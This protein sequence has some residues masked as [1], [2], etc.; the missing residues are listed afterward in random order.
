MCFLTLT[1]RILVGINTNNQPAPRG[2]RGNMKLKQH[3]EQHHNGNNTAFARHLSKRNGKTIYR[4][5]VDR[6][7]TSEAWEV[8][9]GELRPIGMVKV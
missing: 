7:V 6:W 1:E 4:Q 8:K 9:A 2:Q 3:I 5:Q